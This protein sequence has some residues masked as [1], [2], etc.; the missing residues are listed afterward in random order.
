M[1]I[2]LDLDLPTAEAEAL[3]RHVLEHVPATGDF[4]QDAH[5]REAFDELATALRQEVAWVTDRA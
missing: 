2:R 1:S 4:R 5:L 3:L